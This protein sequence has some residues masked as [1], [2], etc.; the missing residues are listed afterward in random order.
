MVPKD[1]YVIMENTHKAIIEKEKFDKVQFL[2]MK[3]SI[4]KIIP[5]YTLDFTGIIGYNFVYNS[6]T[7]EVYH[8]TV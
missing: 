1:Q 6:F 4:N 2:L 5:H 8:G 7:E 3:R